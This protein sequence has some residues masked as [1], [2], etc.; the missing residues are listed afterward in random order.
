MA[1]GEVK[2]IYLL[3]VKGHPDKQGVIKKRLLRTKIHHEVKVVVD[4]K[5]KEAITKFNVLKHIGESA[6]VEAE[7]LTGRTHQIRVHMASIG[8]PVI[9]DDSYGEEE[10]NKKFRRYFK[11]KRQ[12]L[13]SHRLNFK[14]PITGKNIEIVSELPEDLNFVLTKTSKD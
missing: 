13:H 1:K 8:H 6:L 4:E 9:G 5:G 7:I 3:L 10:L 12:F 11:L 2:K 14:H